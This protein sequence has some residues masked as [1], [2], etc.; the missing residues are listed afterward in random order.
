M[1]AVCVSLRRFRLRGRE[2]NL[3]YMPERG[4]RD[5]RAK[6]FGNT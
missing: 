2:I 4:D 5:E 3:R 1:K 6:A